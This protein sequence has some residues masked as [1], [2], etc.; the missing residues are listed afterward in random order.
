MQVLDDMATMAYD[1]VVLGMGNEVSYVHSSMG[2]RQFEATH[3]RRRACA[4]RCAVWEEKQADIWT[5]FC[6]RCRN[7]G[8]CF[9]HWCIVDGDQ[10]GVWVGN[11]S[12]LR[13][14]VL[15]LRE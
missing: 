8:P 5:D 13:S 3:M 14:F 6:F 12:C 15:G 11:A 2:S 4:L 10:D 7:A 9:S 1:K